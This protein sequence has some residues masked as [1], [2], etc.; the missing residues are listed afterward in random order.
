MTTARNGHRPAHPRWALGLLALAQLII[1]L[2]ATIV[3]V[4]LPQ[5]GEDLGFSAATLQWVMSA[6]LVSFGGALLLGGRAADLLGRRRMFITALLLYA[7]SSLAGGLAGAPAVIVGA[8]VIQGFG[9]ALLFPATLSL[10]NTTFAEGPERNRALAVW[11]GAGASGLSLGSLLGGLLTEGLGWQAVFFVNVP[12]GGGAALAALALISA[13]RDRERGRSFDLPGALAATAAVA[14]LVFAIV[15]G[16]QSGWDSPVVVGAIA[17]SVLVA[18]LFVTVEARGR[19]PLLPLRLLRNRNLSAAM[20]I[21]FIFLGTFGALLYVLTIFFQG[22]RGY[23][24]LQTGLAFLAPSVVIFAGTQLGE[25]MVNASSLRATLV[26]GFVLGGAGT[27]ALATQ[28]STD[29]SYLSLAPGIAL[30]AVGQGI[31]WTAMWIAAAEGVDGREQGVASGMASTALQ[32]G[33]A[34]GL[35]LLVAISNQDHSG[36]GLRGALAVGLEHAAYVAA[37]GMALGALVAALRL[38]PL[39][40]GARRPQTQTGAS[41]R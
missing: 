1:A 9:G 35:A 6:Y 40:V 33:G 2:D 24:S 11:G 41:W 21:T 7:G 16:P 28:L 4:A 26:A 14:L 19:D 37:A 32:V 39:R 27:A 22:V 25:R 34:V 30:Y 10:V 18:A 15:Q 17:V 38:R 8:R 5:I 12:L 31:T 3:Y 29:V 20:A 23:D 36:A 13:D